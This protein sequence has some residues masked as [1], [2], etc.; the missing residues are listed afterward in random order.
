MNTI[1]KTIIKKISKI[2]NFFIIPSINSFEITFDKKYEEEPFQKELNERSELFKNI[3]DQDNKDKIKNVLHKTLVGH[4]YSKYLFKIF[5]NNEKYMIIKNEDFNI[6]NHKE[7]DNISYVI[8]NKKNL[9]KYLKQKNNI[10]KYKN[11]LVYN[12]FQCILFSYKHLKK[13]GSCYFLISIPN[14]QI[15]YLLYFLSLI[16][17][18]VYIIDK[19]CIFCHIFKKNNEYIK[20]IEDIQNHNYEF[21][22]EPIKNKQKLIKYFKNLIKLDYYYK[23]QLIFNEQYKLYVY[24]KFFTNIHNI[25]TLNSLYKESYKKNIKNIYIKNILNMNISNFNNDNDNDNIYLNEIKD[26]SQN[27]NK[28]KLIFLK[29]KKK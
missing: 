12:I 4:S 5:T 3:E 28:Y 23:K 22:I 1:E 27:I 9:N 26:K 7:Y 25:N 13:E 15:I 8:D 11:I 16:F 2:D 20:I 19:F 6:D 24:F 14:N 10:K 17:E 21:Q 18:K 29:N